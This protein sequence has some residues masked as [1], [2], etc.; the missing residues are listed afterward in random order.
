MRAV[1]FKVLVEMLTNG[2]AIHETLMLLR[3]DTV[4]AEGTAALKFNLHLVRQ[5]VMADRFDPG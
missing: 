5:R 4:K 2:S 1:A 3:A